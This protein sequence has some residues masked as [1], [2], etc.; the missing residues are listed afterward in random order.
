MTRMN[1][2]N[3]KQISKAYANITSIGIMAM[4][5]IRHAGLF[6]KPVCQVIHETIEMVPQ[7][8]L[9]DVFFRA[10]IN[11]DDSGLV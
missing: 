1:K 5:Q 4:Y 9:G 8:F 7:L 3:T 6:V 2:W 10:R 11:A